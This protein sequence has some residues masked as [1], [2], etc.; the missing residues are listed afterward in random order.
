MFSLG[1]SFYKKDYEYIDY[2]QDQIGGTITLGREFARHFTASVGLGYVDNKSTYNNTYDASLINYYNDK[3]QKTSVF[4][5]LSYDNTDDYYVP[6]EGMKAVLMVEY[7]N[8]SGD[9]FNST[10]Y[11]G[12]GN[13]IKTSGKFGIYYG[14][15]DMIDYD[16]IL[17]AK[18]RFS[19]ISGDKKEYMPIAERLFMGGMGSVRGFNPYSISPTLNT[20]RIGGT[21]TASGSLEASIP[22]SQAAKMRLAF[23]YDY[24]M[25]GRSDITEIKKEGYGVALEWFSPMGPINLVFARAKNADALDRTASFEFTMGQKF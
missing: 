10:L 8:L 9:D 17:R 2:T 16:L 21:Q 1:M 18:G 4:T 6:R 11:T 19:V 7:G 5:S 22:L 12:Y 20:Q 15:E 23:F 13:L 14:L 25:V 24:G 3:Y